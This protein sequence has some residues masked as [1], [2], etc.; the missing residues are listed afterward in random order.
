MTPD[1]LLA[2]PRG[3]RLCLSVAADLDPAVATGVFYAAYELDPGKG[4]SVVLFGAAPPDGVGAEA[5]QR[6]AELMDAL[7]V[8]ALDEGLI[9]RALTESVAT[10]MYWQ[11]PDGRDVLAALPVIRDALVPVAA[12]ILA[13]P[14]AAWWQESR[15]EEQWAINWR[16]PDAPAPLGKNTSSALSAWARNTR[17]EENQWRKRGGGPASAWS[18]S[19]WSIPTRLLG[20]IG[21]VPGGLDLVEDAPGWLDATAVGVHGGG[22]TFEIRTPDDWGQLCRAFPLEVTASRRNDWF[23]ATGRDGRWFIPDWERAAGEW[24]A[25]H[26]T[27]QGYLS[28]AGRVVEL[29]GDGASVLA[30][31]DPD[32]TIWLTDAVPEAAAPRQQWHRNQQG[33]LWVRTG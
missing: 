30:G 22:K 17:T 25:V 19:W 28:C 5:P 8:P 1:Q 3:R 15:A 7:E 9:R 27:V 33:D 2:G 14:E 18:G 6:L 20:T 21:R 29:D 24:D 26:L 23:R 32:R 4:V 31:W 11:P 16:E 10:A 13:S 12:R